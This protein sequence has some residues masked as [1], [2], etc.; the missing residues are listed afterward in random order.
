MNSALK[1]N[2]SQEEL[3]KIFDLYKLNVLDVQ[4][5]KDGII[6]T[7]YCLK[8]G[9]GSK[10]VL[11]VYQNG[12]KSNDAIEKELNFMDEMR[13]SG[14][15]IP[16]V[17]ANIFDKKLTI[18]KDSIGREWR[19]II[20][21]FAQGRHLEPTDFAIIPEL[22][23]YQAKMHLVSS[24][25]NKNS[26]SPN[27]KAM[28][29]WLDKEFNETKSKGLAKEIFSK[30]EEIYNGLKQDIELNFDEI[31][32]LPCGDVHLDYDSDNVIV[33]NGKIKAILDFDDISKQPFILD[34]ANSIW[35][36]LL[37]NKKENYEKILNSY[38]ESYRKIRD[39]TEKEYK[40]LSLFLRMR[41]LTLMCLLYANI[42]EKNR[43]RKNK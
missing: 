24:G 18:F 26:E 5:F 28:V 33:D 43:L 36:W 14:V 13:N 34:T 20:M 22:A 16:P 9:D 7:S 10:L 29:D 35:W 11:R 27:F 38:F 6:N 4:C 23:M 25:L 41:N 12:G 17:M 31:L 37:K 2:G 3:S 15:P 30:I 39:I 21:A 19:A 8:I 1:F 42:P 32:A 40:F